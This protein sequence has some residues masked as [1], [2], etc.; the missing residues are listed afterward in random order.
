MMGC[1]LSIVAPTERKP[2]SADA[3]LRLMHS[4]VAKLPDDRPGDTESAFTDALLSAL[5]M[6]SLTSPALLAFDQQRA[7]GHVKP[8]SGLACG[9]CDTRMREI[10]APLFPASL[11]PLCTRVFRQRKRGKALEPMAWLADSY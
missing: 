2:L 10:R 11:R 8:I 1:V 5:A 9:P 6:F 3:R 4:G 7:E